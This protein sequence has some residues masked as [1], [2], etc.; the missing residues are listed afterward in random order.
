MGILTAPIIGVARETARNRLVRV[1]RPAGLPA[2]LAGQYVL[3][4]RHGGGSRKPY[5]IACSPRE[6][7]RRDELEFLIQVVDG[8]S[9][10]TH[11]GSLI[12]GTL[13][14]VEGPAGSFVLP[15]GQPVLAA[16]LVGGG[17]G[18]APLRAMLHELLEDAPRARLAVV[19]TARAPEELSYSSEL[20]ALH[21]AGRI[22]LVETVTRTA[23]DA[24]AGRCG[25]IDAGMLA[26]LVDGA[27]TWCFVC[28]PDSLV[29]GVPRIL[30]SLGVRQAAIRTEQW[31]DAAVAR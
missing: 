21:A 26:P 28:G 18:I 1:A 5:S 16:L 2:F 17:T 9:P 25:R 19:Q 23:P 12:A 8:E 11:L 10:G 30:A 13:V 20:R 24:W 31:T 29:E 3:L 4:G 6:A 27:E 15:P 14:D 7:E 22:R